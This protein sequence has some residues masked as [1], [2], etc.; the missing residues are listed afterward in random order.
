MCRFIYSCMLIAALCCLAV[1]TVYGVRVWLNQDEIESFYKIRPQTKVLCVGNSQTG[2]T[3]ED[4]KELDVETKWIS[5]TSMPVYWMRLAEIDRRD[6]FCNVKVVM[7][8]CCAPARHVWEDRIARD[9]ARTLPVSWRYIFQMPTSFLEVLTQC[10][11]PLSREWD[12]CDA[13]A[14]DD[15]R[16]TSLSKEEQ[17]NELDEVY[18]GV[19]YREPDNADEVVLEYLSRIQSICSRRGVRLIL[20]F[21]PLV[22]GNPNRSS[23]R[24][25]GWKKTLLKRGYNVWDFRDACADNAFRD[26]HH[27]TLEGRQNFTRKWVGLMIK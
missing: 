20:F 6:G 24:L 3:W 11:L 18:N 25:N 4:S 8:D 16:W 10:L 13:P 22:D 12:F 19:G 1:I 23:T 17:K 9:I 27:L 2:C 15:R 14:N 7:M 5:A 26:S 21:A